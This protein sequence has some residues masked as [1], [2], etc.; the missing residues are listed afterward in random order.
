MMKL[1][2]WTRNQKKVALILIAAG[3]LSLVLVIMPVATVV[4]YESVFSRR[5]EPASWL[6]F[7]VADFEGLSVEPCT[8]ESNDGQRL[9]GYHYE[10]GDSS[11]N[12][13]VILVHGFGCGGQNS[14]MPLADFFTSNGYLVFSYD[15]TANGNSEGNSVNG[16]PQGV[17]DLDYALRYVKSEKRYANLPILLLGHSWGA[18]SA[19]AVLNLHCDVSAAVLVSGPNSS[20]DMM[21]SESK[22]IAGPLVYPGVP[23]LMLYER[24][25]FGKYSEYSV[26]DGFASS[27]AEILVVHSMDDAAVPPEIGYNKFYE[28]Y[29]DDSRFEFVSYSNR[30]HD[31]IF[32]SLSAEQ[33]RDRLNS[34]YLQYVEENA[35]THDAETKE[36]FFDQYPDVSLCF[37]LDPALMEQILE[38]YNDCCEVHNE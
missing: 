18:Y 32:Y 19:G 23:Y 14:F 27:D 37:E 3:F 35:L 9:A 21:L 2:R 15:A 11:V 30:G 36:A 13:V 1:R 29:Q 6:E 10:K 20:L 31:R 5:I 16:L 8:F 26:L 34:D 38:T 7:D 33:Y 12:G 4:V 28:R 25:K 24:L 17:A 22:R